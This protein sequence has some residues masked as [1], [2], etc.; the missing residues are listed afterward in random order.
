MTQFNKEWRELWATKRAIIILVVMLI[1]GILSPLT[2]K[3]LPDLIGSM[4]DEENITITIT[5]VTKADAIQQFVQNI[6]QMFMF[7]VVLVSFGMVVN[8]RERGNMTLMFSHPISRTGF[9]LAKFAALALILALGMIVSGGAA[10]L[11]TVILFDAPAIGGFIGLI[12]LAYI[13][14]M[15]FAALGI[16]ASTLGKSNASAIGYL[17]LFIAVLL[18]S[19]VLTDFSPGGLIEWGGNLALELDA[20]AQWGALITSV[21]VIIGAIYGACFALNQQEIG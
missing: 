12:V 18:F 17:F 9:I 2:A 3:I 14:L 20:S 5:E 6:G 16:L 11:Y 1:F 19:G 4:G 10:Y 7:M 8:E 13:Y 15:V 21:V